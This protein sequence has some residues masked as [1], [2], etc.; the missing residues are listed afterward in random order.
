MLARAL[1]QKLLPSSQQWLI[2]LKMCAVAAAAQLANWPQFMAAAEKILVA[3]QLCINPRRDSYTGGSRSNSMRAFITADIVGLQLSLLRAVTKV[4]RGGLLSVD[5]AH[6]ATAAMDRPGQT[7]C[8]ADASLQLLAATCSILRKRLAQQ[9]QPNTADQAGQQQQRSLQ[10]TQLPRQQQKL[11]PQDITAAHQQ[12]LQQLLG[13]GSQAYIQQ[14]EQIMFPP[15][16]SMSDAT[17]TVAAAAALPLVSVA[18][19]VSYMGDYGPGWRPAG[20]SRSVP[21][22]TNAAKLRLSA[23]VAADAFQLTAEVLQL[24]LCVQQRQPDTATDDDPESVDAAF[25]GNIGTVL[26]LQLLLQPQQPAAAAASQ[27][28]Q[29]PERHSSVGP[30]SSS[31]SSSSSIMGGRGSLYT[32]AIGAQVL[33]SAMAHVRWCKSVHA[34]AVVGVAWATLVCH[35]VDWLHCCFTDQGKDLWLFRDVMTVLKNISALLVARHPDT[36]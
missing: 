35:T 22:A 12:Q 21:E 17:N 19:A 29:L 2:L 8:A 15:G 28:P 3:V 34:Q 24:L 7:A 30:S 16:T 36:A 4:I 18:H 10:V 9:K 33:Q 6:L 11:Q 13:D 31:S 26:V 32:T 27:G 20:G 5:S 25:V 1:F 14:V 23:V